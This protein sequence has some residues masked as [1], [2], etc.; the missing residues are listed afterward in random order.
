MILVDTSVW[1][2]FL[3]GTE[4]AEADRLAD[5]LRADEKL[6]TCGIICAELLQ[7]VRSDREYRS[8]RRTLRTLTYL[9]LEQEGHVLAADLYRRVRQTGRTVRNT[10]DCIIAACALI[11][12]VPLLQRDRDFAV[13]ASVSNLRLLD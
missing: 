11:H 8:L 3:R 9:P 5:A 1:I 4:S 2:D 12:D 7:G 13:I 10:T 6:C